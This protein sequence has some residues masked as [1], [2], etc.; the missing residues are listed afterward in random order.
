MTAD[1]N[2]SVYVNGRFLL[3]G[4]NWQKVYVL[5]IPSAFLNEG[6]N[7]LVVVAGNAEKSP[8]AVIYAIVA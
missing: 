4:N 2:F 5:E 3:N 6:E 1:N 8:A 7:S